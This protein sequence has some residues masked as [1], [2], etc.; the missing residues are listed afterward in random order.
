M[1]I[2]NNDVRVWLIICL[3]LLR[4]TMTRTRLRER[5]PQ[6]FNLIQ[7]LSQRLESLSNHE[8]KQESA[9][10]LELKNRIKSLMS[11]DRL[12]QKIAAN[13]SLAQVRDFVFVI[14]VQNR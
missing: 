10:I 11:D 13:A 5:Q 12:K 3:D 6:I 4:L 7:A 2:Y 1:I 8:E 14:N 9:T